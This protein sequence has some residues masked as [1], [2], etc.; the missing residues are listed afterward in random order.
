VRM[1][2]SPG[3]C[4]SRTRW[5]AGEREREQLVRRLLAEEQRSK[6]SRECKHNR[7]AR[8]W[9]DA[10][11]GRVQ[12]QEAKGRWQRER[13]QL[14]RRLLAEEAKGANGAGGVS[15]QTL[16]RSCM[17][18][19]PYSGRVQLQEAKGR[20]QREREQLVRRLLAEG[21]K[22]ET[23]G[24]GP[25]AG[26]RRGPGLRPGRRPR[27]RLK[28]RAQ[29]QEQTQE[30]EQAQEQPA[31]FVELL[32]F[33]D[34]RQLPIH[35]WRPGDPSQSGKDSVSSGRDPAES[36]R[37]CKDNQAGLKGSCAQHRATFPQK[38]G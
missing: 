14:V 10:Q 31:D 22:D 35:P 23:N 3:E 5:D 28:A 16:R 30:Q 32:Q 2:P 1:M 26:P 11:S 38:H 19:M 15:A 36:G 37:D 7:G 34:Q 13:E 20:W 17:G 6:W 4:S 29:A 24:T 27:P 8:A 9:N 21:A 12:L 33:L 18:M 25:G